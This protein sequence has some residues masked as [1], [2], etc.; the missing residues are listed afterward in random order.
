M[1]CGKFIYF[2][3][4][5]RSFSEGDSKGGFVHYEKHCQIA[6]SSN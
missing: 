3:L 6:K 2:P 1:Q 4:A 5:R